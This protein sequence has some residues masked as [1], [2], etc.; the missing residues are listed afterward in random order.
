[1]TFIEEIREK[2]AKFRDTP[3]SDEELN[4]AVDAIKERISRI[5]ND[6]Y[7]FAV[8]EITIHYISSGDNAGTCKFWAGPAADAPLH[9]ALFY[10]SVPKF[11]KVLDEIGNL[12]FTYSGE[13]G[14]R[15]G[16]VHIRW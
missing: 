7:S 9:N 15:D 11:R 6:P 13:Y 5:A 3:L 4:S 2:Q 10:M 8:N 1:M 12:G 16:H 14:P